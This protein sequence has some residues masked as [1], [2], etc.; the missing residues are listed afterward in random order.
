MVFSSATF[1]LAFLPLFLIVYFALP[2]R[3][4]K[5]IVLL[6]ASLIFYAWGEPVYIWLMVVS[7]AINWAAG[8]LI[9]ASHREGIRKLVLALVLMADL[10]ILCFFKYEGFIAENVNAL[11]G[12]QIIPDYELPLPIGISFYTLQAVSYVVDVYR[13]DVTAQKNPLYLGMYIAMFPQLVAGPIVRYEDIEDQIDDRRVTLAGFCAGIRLF[14][15][16]CGK[17]VLLANVMAILADN[18]L[19]SGGAAIGLIGAWA[20][21]AAYSFQ[22]FFDFGGY[23]DMA[24]GMGKMMGFNY[25]RNF[26]YPYISHSA[27]EFWRRWH[28]TL[29]NFFRDYVYIPLGGNRTSKRR[30][31]FN[32][33]VVWGLTGIWHGAAWNFLLWGLYYG[34]LLIC[35]K[36]FLLGLL[37]RAP[38]V[39]RR[40]WCIAVFMFG[41][42]I[43]WIED[44][45]T[46]AE[47]LCAM[48]GAYGL[49]G[50]T[51][52]WMLGA[53]EWWP[54]LIPCVL[55]STPL[56]PQVRECLVAWACR[57]KPINVVQQG[58]AMQKMQKSTDQ[59]ETTL[60]MDEA[61]QANASRGRIGVLQS[62]FALT[63]IACLVMLGLSIIS[64]ISG[65]FNPFI[66]F[67]F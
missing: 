54:M 28:M 67:R 55:A 3:P 53:W 42:L 40:I 19:S 8:V 62:V 7:M 20:G 16:G 35:E 65:S 51:S 38:S 32:I 61:K 46:F 5:N 37:D 29:G 50:S 15:V 27:T 13:R 45:S 44:P 33:A 9:S 34:V 66:Y 41:W 30:W 43:F 10:G 59:C 12:A 18:M 39:V 25:P 26:N 11:L 24:I 2:W 31:M 1:L 6:I 52:L 57:R 21:L 63:D 36:N 14:C 64:V 22:I 56:V 47:Y 4:A 23:S 58:L 60:W 17:K 49:T 48:F